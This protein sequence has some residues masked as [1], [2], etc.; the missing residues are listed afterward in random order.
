MRAD[1]VGIVHPE[2]IDRLAG[3][4][5]DLDLVDEQALVHQLVID[6]SAGYLGER[7]G[8]GF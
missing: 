2:V 8:Q 5:L 3:R 7:L 6:L 1:K 4:D